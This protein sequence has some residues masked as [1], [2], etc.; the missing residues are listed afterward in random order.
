MKKFFSIMAMLLVALCSNAAV[1]IQ[2]V[3]GWYE[4]G[5]VT[6]TT[7]AGKAYNVYVRAEGGSYTKLDNELVRNYGSYGRADMVGLKAGN[8]QFKVVPVSGGAEETANAA[9]TSVFTA[10]AYDRSGFA[11]QGWS[12]GVGAYKTTV[13]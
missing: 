4:G 1:T 3:K 13:H 10:K 2:E 6:W 5:H 9:E 8:Y 11:H 12:E 7:E